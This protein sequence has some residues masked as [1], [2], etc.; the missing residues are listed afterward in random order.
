MSL[1]GMLAGASVVFVA[2]APGAAP[3]AD[4]APGTAPATGDAAKDV[5]TSTLEQA[6]ADPKQMTS[7]LW[8][9]FVNWIQVKGPGVLAAIVLLI[10]AYVASR[11]VRRFII[12]AL[13]RA[14]MDLTLSKF[15]GNLAKWVIIIF[16]LVTCAGTFGINTA[17]FAAAIAAAGLAIGLALQGNLGNLASGVLLLVFRPFKIGDAVIVAGQAGIVDGIDLFTTNLDTGDNRRIIIPNGAIFGGVI[18]NQSHHPRRRVDYTIAVAGGNDVER[19]RG[20]FKDVLAKV[21]AANIGALSD[22]LNAV[23]LADINPNQMW[24]VNLW[25]E[26]PKVGA[27]RERLIIELRH[28][29]DSNG[30]GPAAPVQLVKQVS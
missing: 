30:L 21:I 12:V 24:T 3:A 6:V 17:S 20:M 11:W 14:K 27:V 8:N 5:V 4:P 2:P 13:T 10:V 9:D 15:L 25:A 26:T 22:P 23:G 18:E 28:A 1:L 7:Q 19:V 29:V 16:S